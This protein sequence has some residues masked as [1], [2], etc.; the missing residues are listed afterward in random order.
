[1]EV[2]YPTCIADGHVNWVISGF[3]CD[4]CLTDY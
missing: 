1:M 2:N 4:Y 3:A